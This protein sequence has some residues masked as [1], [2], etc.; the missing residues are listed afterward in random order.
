[1]KK[2]EGFLSV[3]E[4]AAFLGV[5]RLK[6]TDLILKNEIPAIKLGGRWFLDKDKLEKHIKDTMDLN[7][8]KN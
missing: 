2:M 3:Q 6:V 5:N 8:D 4:A 7:V 1:M